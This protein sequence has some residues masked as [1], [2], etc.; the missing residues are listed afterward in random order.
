MK[1]KILADFQICIRVPLK[2][3]GLHQ[4]H[5]TENV[6]RQFFSVEHVMQPLLEFASKIP[7]S[8]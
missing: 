3:H 7:V 5:F 8:F 2:N 1:T 6:S 4:A